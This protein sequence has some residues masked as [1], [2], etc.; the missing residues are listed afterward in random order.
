MT[1]LKFIL[2]NSNMKKLLKI[3]QSSWLCLKFPFLYPRHR[4]FGSHYTNWTLINFI[5]KWKPLSINHIIVKIETKEGGHKGICV[6]ENDT[7]YYFK[8]IDNVLICENPYKIIYKQNL[9]DLNIKAIGISQEKNRP[10]LHTQEPTECNLIIIQHIHA[11]WLYYTCKFFK[12]L[13]DWP[14]QL[15]HC[16]PT[17]TELDA[18]PEVWRQ[19]FGIQICKEIKQALLKKG[20]Y[21]A[22]L[23]YRILQIKEK[24]GYLHWYDVNGCEETFDIIRKYEDISSQIC[25]DCGEPATKQTKGWILNVC[26]KCYNKR[27]GE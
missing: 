18:L 15:F 25:F 7:N 24:W 14:L 26:D 10:I 13:N 2:N 22:L 27:H 12:W 17:Y 1:F 23:R 5:H 11:K 21:K 8:L 4:M 20:G 16:L 3:I 6:Y 9:N 19:K